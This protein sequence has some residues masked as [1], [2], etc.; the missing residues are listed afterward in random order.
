M[1]HLILAPRYAPW[2]FF[3]W[4][5]VSV[6][7]VTHLVISRVLVCSLLSLSLDHF[8]KF[9]V[10]TGSRSVIEHSASRSLLVMANDVCHL[11]S[12]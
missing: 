11:K 4:P 8:Y 5:G 12:I 6:V 7:L 3:S 1:C 10:D 9:Q 2:S